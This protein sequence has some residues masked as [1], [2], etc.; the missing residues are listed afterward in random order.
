MILLPVKS[1]VASC[2]FVRRPGWARS[3]QNIK[4]KENFRNNWFDK[5]KE[6]E[7]GEQTELVSPVSVIL[8]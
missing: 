5:M 3:R 6:M 2:T 1:A 4:T 7:N 8:Q